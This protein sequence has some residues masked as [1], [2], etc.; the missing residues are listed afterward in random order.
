MYSVLINMCL[1]HIIYSNLS[2]VPV[3]KIYVSVLNVNEMYEVMIIEI[4]AQFNLWPF[5]H[6]LFNKDHFIYLSI[7]LSIQLDLKRRKPKV[8]LQISQNRNK[9]W[10]QC[11]IA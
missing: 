4:I 10:F 8:Q 1:Q 2:Y 6:L 9:N 11:M 5:I 7:Y 3:Y